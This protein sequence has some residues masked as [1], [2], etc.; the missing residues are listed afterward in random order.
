MDEA[1]VVIDEA[2]DELDDEARRRLPAGGS[3]LVK[4]LHQLSVDL[5][6]TADQ[7]PGARLREPAR[8]R[9]GSE[10]RQL[11][12]ANKALASLARQGIHVE[13]IGRH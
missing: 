1:A 10:L 8:R 13:P 7:A 9:P 2:A 12:Q 11:G 5:Q 4:S 6:A 3:Q